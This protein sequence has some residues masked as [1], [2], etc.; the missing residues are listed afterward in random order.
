MT[1]SLVSYHKP[2]APASREAVV[3]LCLEPERYAEILLPAS[4]PHH[5]LCVC[6]H[7]VLV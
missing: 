5:L 3:A 2:P 1:W 7:L 4:P 6:T